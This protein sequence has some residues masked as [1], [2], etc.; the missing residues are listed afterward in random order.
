ML[1]TY[2]TLIIEKK[3]GVG[4]YRS[5]RRD[6][7]NTLFKYEIKKLNKNKTFTTKKKK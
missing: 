2:V 1:N 4:R 5:G 3:E 6:C 7:V